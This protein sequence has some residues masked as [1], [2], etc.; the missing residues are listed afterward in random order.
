[1]IGAIAPGKEADI[2]GVDGDPVSDITAVTRVRA[3]S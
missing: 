1:M 2:I 3:W